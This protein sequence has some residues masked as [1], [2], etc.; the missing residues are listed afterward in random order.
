[1]IVQFSFKREWIDEK[2]KERINPVRGAERIVI[3]AGA[4]LKKSGPADLTVSVSEEQDAKK[5]EDALKA[6]LRE[7]FQVDKPEE[8]I[9]FASDTREEVQPKKSEESQKKKDSSSSVTED[10]EQKKHSGT[11][12]KNASKA[13][14]DAARGYCCADEVNAYFNELECVFSALKQMNAVDTIW[15]RNLL[16]SIDAGYGFSDFLKKLADF[17]IQKGLLKNNEKG[18]AQEIVIPFYPDGEKQFDGWKL[19]LQK[20]STIASQNERAQ[21]ERTKAIVSLDISQWISRMQTEEVSMYLRRIFDQSSRIICVFR[22]PFLELDIVRQVESALQDVLDVRTLIVPPMQMKEMTKYLS[23]KL[24]ELGFSVDE[25]CREDFEQWLLYERNDGSFYGFKTLEKMIHQLIYHK[26]LMDG[27]AGKEA[28]RRITREDIRSL[29]TDA[30]VGE[31][32]YQLLNKMI[33]LTQVKKRVDEIVTQ[34]K[35][36]KKM[37]LEGKN[38]ERPAIHMMFTGKPGTGKTTV[39]RLLAAILREEGILRKGWLVEVR[40]RDLCGRYVGSTTPKTTAYCRDAYG[41]VLFIDEAYELFRENNQR[42]Y[43]REALSAL[44]VEMENHRD[45]FCVILAG[46]KEEMDIMVSGNPGLRDRI[47]YEIEFPDYTRE[48]MTEIFFSMMDGKFEYEKE[49]REVVKNFFDSLPQE[50]I[51]DR[52][53]SNARFV[54]NLFERVWGK[55][56]YR[57]RQSKDEAL[58]VRCEDMNNVYEEKE[59]QRL[60]EG[61]FKKRIGFEV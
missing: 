37:R 55:A 59:Y 52:Q 30:T 32:P 10:A 43:G 31:D 29:D 44:A 27:C 22:I 24:G 40:G 35:V 20:I 2:R 8:I 36:H 56:A 51:D 17:Y 46:Y 15:S 19:A 12:S 1:M 28:S 58:I 3:G 45:D 13:E 53:F 38:V 54:R 7:E 11:L 6:Y 61:K 47:P 26:A 14:K 9:T 50:V 23:D 16:V 4:K 57:N 5:V 42:D 39:A 33:G 41:S 34:I 48:E 18:N 49:L 60:M 25:G 21:S